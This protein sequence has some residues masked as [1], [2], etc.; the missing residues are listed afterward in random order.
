MFN[1]TINWKANLQHIVALSSIE[2]KYVALAEALEERI[3]ISGYVTNLGLTQDSVC[4]I[5]DSQSSIHLSTN[6]MY[7]IRTKYIDNRRH[8]K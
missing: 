1:N 7:H 3:W 4:I 6:Q 8:F 5:C 2:T